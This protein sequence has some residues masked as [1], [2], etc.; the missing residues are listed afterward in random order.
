MRPLSGS[1]YV[2]RPASHA[3]RCKSSMSMAMWC[4]LTYRSTVCP[5][6]QVP[7][8]HSVDGAQVPGT[9]M[10]E[11]LGVRV[12][13]FVR[14]PHGVGTGAADDLMWCIPAPGVMMR[15]GT[16]S[17]SV[18]VVG[19]LVSPLM[20]SFLIPDFCEILMDLGRRQR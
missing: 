11:A 5:R 2:S 3:A 10:H 18:C 17:T 19:R 4:T 8:P 15:Q 6:L 20:W 12:L 16:R 13:N 9:V 1:M 14:P 7:R